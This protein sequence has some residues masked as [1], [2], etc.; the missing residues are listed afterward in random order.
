[1]GRTTSQWLSELEGVLPGWIRPLRPHLAGLAAMLVDLE[2]LNDDAV[3]ATTV[4]GAEGIWLTLYA[5][6]LGIHRVPGESDADLRK[7]VRN[8]EDVVTRPAI[9]AAVNELLAAYTVEQARMFEHFETG[10]FAD[11]NFADQ[12]TNGTR[13]LDQHNAFTLVVPALTADASSYGHFLMDSP[14]PL[15]LDPSGALD[16]DAA[17]VDIDTYAVADS[18]DDTEHAVYA[19]IQAT[20]ERMRAAGVRWWLLRD[21]P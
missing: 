20:V 11:I 18:A 12:P 6:G 13:I 1:M 14:D 2:A 21:E 19:A 3:E 4:A 17:Y 8:V 7:R 10:F 16:V 15:N 9:L 5:R